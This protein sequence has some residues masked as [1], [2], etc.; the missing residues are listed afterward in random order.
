M[1]EIRQRI[2]VPEMVWQNYQIRLRGH[3]DRR[4]AVRF[5]GFTIEHEAT[6]DGQPITVMTGPVIDQSA[7]YGIIGQLR[8]LGI[9]LI[10]VQPQENTDDDENEGS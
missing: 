9:E 10:S 3:L 7:L 2:R 6:A 8:N 1:D 4:W 5:E